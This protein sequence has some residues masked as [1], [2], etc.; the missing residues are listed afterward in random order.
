MEKPDLIEYWQASALKDLETMQHL[1]DSGDY[2]WALFMG[3]LVIEKLLKALFVKH[4][5]I[6][7]PKTH[8]LLRLANRCEL[9][10]DENQE[11]CLDT[12]TAFNI[13]ARYPDYEMTF[14]EQ[15]THDFAEPYIRKVEELKIWLIQ[16]ISN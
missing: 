12:L 11:D 15:C 13:S 4:V 6:N 16:Q 10:L 9:Q 2:H 8:D 5:D 1:F 14:Y 3:H 7:P